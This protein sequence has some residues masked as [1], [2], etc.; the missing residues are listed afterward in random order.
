MRV[1]VSWLKEYID[2]NLPLIEVT[3]IL[4]MAGLEVDAIE[5]VTLG[6]SGVVVGR[7]ISTEKHPDA[8]KLTVAKV[9]DGI[10]E[11][12]VVCGAKNCRPGIKV[13][14]ARVGAS[15]PGG[16]DKP[17]KIKKTKIRGVESMGMLCAED[18]LLLAD[19][20][21][22]IIELPEELKEGHDLSDHFSEQ[23]LEVSLTP[24]LGHCANMVGVA[25]ELHAVTEEPMHLPEVVVKKESGEV[26]EDSVKV[27][28][29]DTIGCPR[30]ACRLI[31]K[32]KVAPSPRWLQNRLI[33]SGIRPVNNVVDI[34]N[35]VLLE[36][37]H[38][39]HAFDFDLIEGGEI[40]V[41][42][43]KEREPFVSL[44]GK[45]RILHEEDVLICDQKR[46]VAIGG[47]M[48]GLNSEVSD[49]TENVL[50]EAAYF[51]PSSIRKTSKRQG[52][53]TESSRRFERGSD[54]NQVL[55]ALDR[56]ASLIEAIAGGEVA[57]GVVDVREGDFPEKIITCRIS[58]I[59]ALLGVTFSVGEVET[60]FDKLYL[61]NKWDGEDTFTVTIP[62]YR[63]DLNIEVDLI[64]EVARVYG[65]DNFHKTATV[66]HTSKTEHA[67]VFLFERVVR[68]RL[69]S[70][71][72]QEFLTC[73]LVGP[74]ILGIVQGPVMPKEAMIKVL[75][76]TSIEQSCLRTSLLPGLLQVV[77]YNY[78][79]QT[80][81]IS[82][83]EVGKIHYKD[84]GKYHEEEVA[85]IVLTGKNHPHFWGE[86]PKDVD[87]YDLKGIVE[88]LLRE[89]G[90]SGCVYRNNNIST[91]HPGR[92]AS[93]YLGELELGS[94]GE[95]HPSILRRLDVPQKVFFAEFNL[96]D[97]YQNKSCD[98]KMVPVP[99][100]PGSERD[101]TVT[102]KE[103][104]ATSYII[105]SIASVDSHLLENCY[106]LDVY[107][108]EKL[109]PGIKN[110]TFRFVYRDKEQTVAQ[111]T[112]DK[113][114]ARITDRVRH[115]LSSKE[116]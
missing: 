37:G 5:T 23:V 49:K 7:V 46:A 18:E 13:A 10:E 53:L 6:F 112:V 114:H 63:V 64:E 72:L 78:D 89:L 1:P 14:L 59:N 40:I 33:A 84:G 96:K 98:L 48:G 27:T 9:T 3:K 67:P 28:V 107:T 39:L 113:E 77:K 21:E 106:I 43:A 60:I 100:Y 35:Y 101:W 24:N 87:F 58:R 15:L 69:L 75:N 51:H 2:I 20:S 16:G 42:K 111:E 38:P 34:T 41:R 99:I 61:P 110:V 86:K 4:T 76:P 105:E 30:Y 90:I 116:N 97:L 62:T 56:A 50:L 32:V 26:I 54:P 94:L 19:N 12:Q 66:S 109:G 45:E 108:S 102:L 47:V 103:G 104:I 81:D 82:G 79:H 65:Y 115:L 22:G 57:K 25:R 31:K 88:N 80:T 85:A 92:Q 52:L 74:T 91:L 29:H 71:G 93:V 68:Q 95:V 55:Y 36:F 17:F 8:D 11:F 44:D 73:D 70:E 83:F